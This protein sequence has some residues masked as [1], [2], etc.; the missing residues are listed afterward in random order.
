MLEVLLESRAVRTPR[1]LYEAIISAAAHGALVVALVVGP[2]LASSDLA[3]KK[4][5]DVTPPVYI[6]PPDR[7]QSREQHVQ[8]V[9]MGGAQT[10]L[11]D[12][13]R[14]PVPDQQASAATNQEQTDVSLRHAEQADDAFSVLEVDSAAVRDPASAAPA[15]PPVMMSL[16]IEGAATIRFVVDT[17]GRA[18]LSTVHTVAATNPAFE[19]AVLE[20]LPKMRFHPARIGRTAVRQMESEEFKFELKR[21]AVA[22][23]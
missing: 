16:A 9:A 21:F 20:A 14:A 2:S 12:A 8:F 13:G 18:D 19:H 3:E 1:P 4:S 23:P 10:E 11:R 5:D 17:S 6:A 15:Y 22:R 7:F